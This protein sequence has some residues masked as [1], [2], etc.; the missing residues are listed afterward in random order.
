MSL[1]R[2]VCNMT[3]I[4][5]HV[6]FVPW[7][8]LFLERERERVC[9]CVCVCTCV[10]VCVCTVF[11]SPHSAALMFTLFVNDYESN[12]YQYLIV[13]IFCLYFSVL[14]DTG[15][16]FVIFLYYHSLKRKKTH[17]LFSKHWKLYGTVLQH[18]ARPQAARKTTEFL[19]NNNVQNSLLALYLPR[20]KPKHT[21]LEWVGEM[22][23]RQSECPCKCARVVS[24]TQAGIGG[25]SRTSNSQPY[26]VH[27][28]EM[29]GSYWFS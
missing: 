12:R 1:N 28:R 4:L 23:S 21:Q 13:H 20:L 22:C 8:L 9:V 2:V 16:H 15:R 18:N 26:L 25:H 27:A 5:H 24:S 17:F 3:D 10:C 14:R 7:L 11:V 29:V 6:T 19:A